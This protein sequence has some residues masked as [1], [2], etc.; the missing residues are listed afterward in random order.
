MSVELIKTGKTGIDPDV[1]TN[2]D[3]GQAPRLPPSV[4]MHGA[5]EH[6]CMITNQWLAGGGGRGIRTH[7]TGHP[8]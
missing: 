2:L 6:Q 3:D 7:E 8:A 5:P 1:R 4:I